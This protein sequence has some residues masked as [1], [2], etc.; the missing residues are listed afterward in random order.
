MSIG[1]V[2]HA[3]L[4]SAVVLSVLGVI[5][6]S[7][8][9]L[10]SGLALVGIALARA[11]KLHELTRARSLTI[12]VHSSTLVLLVLALAT[13]PR[14]R[15]DA[16]LMVVMLGIYNRWLLRAGQRDDFVILGASMVLVAAATTVTPGIAFLFILLGIIPATLW[17]AWAAMLLGV[18]EQRGQDARSKQAEVAK[19][20]RRRA[21]PAMRAIAVLG[22]VFTIPG[23]M[24]M[25]LFPRYHFGRV[26]APGYFMALPG[27]SDSMN[28]HTGGVN[29]PGAGAVVLRA[30]PRSGQSS[31]LEG[32]YARFYS[33]DFF[34]G[35]TWSASEQGRRYALFG[36][37]TSRLRWSA[38]WTEADG[39]NMVRLELERLTPRNQYHPLPA[40]G[41]LWPAHIEIQDAGQTLSGTW[42]TH[43][44]WKGMTLDY[45]A[46]LGRPLQTASMLPN[47]AKRMSA[48]AL[49]LP[50]NLDPRVVALAKRLVQ[51][52][53]E[54]ASAAQKAEAI[55]RHFDRGF[56]YSLDPLEGT[57]Q[58]PVTRFLFQAR[59]GHCELYAGAL[60][61]LLRS[62]GVHARV[63]TGYYGGRW[64][65]PGGYLEFAEQDAHAWVEAYY[66]DQGWRWLDATPEDL[67]SRRQSDSFFTWVQDLYDAAEAAWFENVLDFSE[68]DRKR[69]MGGLKDV[70]AGA[71]SF[72][73]LGAAGLSG[74]QTG[75]QSGRSAPWGLALVLLLGGAP[76]VG[77]G[78][79]VHR[80]RTS[81]QV[82]GAK[83]RALLSESPQP[84]L[85]LGALV[86]KLEG[87]LQQ[88]AQRCV[89]QYE[90]MRFG[91]PERAPKPQDVA[92][93]VAE[94]ARFK[95]SQRARS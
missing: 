92:K 8:Y 65:A 57:D 74:N 53:G 83:L 52:L 39:P 13:F 60:A 14:S 88:R 87:E 84:Q 55:L 31:G 17:A 18:G 90:A 33:L 12:F 50:D 26:F 29:S 28:M 45:K 89:R 2:H 47:V 44:G 77:V 59:K 46:D 95:K 70:F 3:A 75:S 25:L 1:K 78:Y 93:A 9:L 36:R 69:M 68:S 6:G 73:G 20:A 41:R 91:A 38:Q 23:A 56:T 61:I 76:V 82:L 64:N 37:R 21:P 67:R 34:D 5:S 40:L 54:R 86:E 85:P 80:R 22:V 42:V 15:F 16:V 4:T 27:A 19:I 72:D 79:R 48:R 63:V 62:A 10:F 43:G 7:P 81:P 30:T 51:S 32:L 11:S 71:F 35:K 24:A 66:P 94:L 58:D 49:Q